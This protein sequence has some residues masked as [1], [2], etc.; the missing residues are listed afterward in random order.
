MITNIS[1]LLE[2][3]YRN[4]RAQMDVAVIGMS[5][6]ADS[7]LCAILC[8]EALGK[9]KVFSLHMPMTARDREYF[10]SN[11]L[12]AAKALGIHAQTIPIEPIVAP[13]NSALEQDSTWAGQADLAAEPLSP[14]NLGNS[15]ARVRMC[16]L[17]GAG[18]HLGSLLQQRVRVIGTGNLSED[19]IGYDTKG[20][21]ALGDVFIIGDLF[22]S[23]VYQLLD[24]FANTIGFPAELIDRVPSAGLWQGQTD[25]GELGYSYNEME[26]SIRKLK[27]DGREPESEIDRF[28]AAR[29]KAHKHKHEAPP[30]IPLRHHCD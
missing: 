25:E 30:V 2:V 16:L 28:V 6:G 12:A 23:E 13:L 17:Y 29:H 20:G 5:G 26:G 3:V 27:L 14:T 21:D 1:E 11:S 24:H 8:R 9:D 7:T 4:I 10:N 22:K 18:H 15:R 19:Y